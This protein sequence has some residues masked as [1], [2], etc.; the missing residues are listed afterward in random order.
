M[1]Y[2][3][4]SFTYWHWL[5]ITKFKGYFEERERGKDLIILD[6]DLRRGYFLSKTK[7]QAGNIYV[8]GNSFEPVP[9]YH[10]VEV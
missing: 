3:F 6:S 9:M 2:Y 5:T 4:I 10:Q 8:K 1:W 7:F